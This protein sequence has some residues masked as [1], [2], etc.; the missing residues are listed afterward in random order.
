M[1]VCNFP[2]RVSYITRVVWNAGA[3]CLLGILAVTIPSKVSGQTASPETH[4]TGLLFV[5]PQKYENIPLVPPPL[6][7]RLPQAV[8]WAPYFPT[9]GNQ[10]AQESCAGWAVGYALKSFQV[11]AKQRAV[12][13]T[14]LQHVTFSPSFIYNQI[15]QIPS[16]DSLAYLTDALDL[17]VI[18]GDVP[19]D[20][21]QYASLDCVRL[22][23]NR[24]KQ[25]ASNYRAA[26]WR[27]VD[28]KDVLS[29]K[30]HLAAGFPVV[31]GIVVDDGFKHLKDE[32]YSHFFRSKGVNPHA[33]VVIGYDDVMGAFHVQNSWGTDWGEGGRGWISYP[34]FI[35]IVREAYVVQDIVGAYAPVKY[36]S[37]VRSDTAGLENPISGPREEI[38]P[39][40]PVIPQGNGEWYV[41]VGSHS[42]LEAARLQQQ[43]ILTMMNGIQAEVYDRYRDNPYYAVI[44]GALL[45]KGEAI[46]LRKRAIAAGLPKDTYLWTFPK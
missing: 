7:G 33:V 37:S 10:G 38:H 45:T 9:P 17:L 39:G 22:P 30:A 19:M 13:P 40:H 36:V 25:I 1:N 24:T 28:T 26:G 4:R 15:T 3:S 12:E 21:F 34:A 16:C 44:I 43:R 20:D 35:Q 42:T 18:Q 29:I 14:N 23:D 46:T 6:G 32:V 8:D 41:I 11:F 5:E 27:R 31:V 2:P